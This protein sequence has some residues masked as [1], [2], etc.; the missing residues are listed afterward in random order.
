MGE[1]LTSS[2]LI[3]T[4]EKRRQVTLFVNEAAEGMLGYQLPLVEDAPDFISDH[5]RPA[6][7]D[8]VLD[9]F[10]DCLFELFDRL[11]FHVLLSDEL[12]DLVSE[13]VPVVEDVVLV[14][15]AE[16]VG[17]RLLRSEGVLGQAGEDQRGRP[18]VV[19]VSHIVDLRVVAHPSLLADQEVRPLP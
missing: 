2:Q 5:S 14:D 16:L 7:C 6:R 17:A 10:D 15:V 12:A 19:Q 4:L 11:G 1:V 18:V 9:V 3:V 8:P 13:L